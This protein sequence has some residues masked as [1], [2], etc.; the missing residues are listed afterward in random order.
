MTKLVLALT[1]AVAVTVLVAP[2]AF[3]AVEYCVIQNR[4]GQMG[5]TNADPTYGWTK[6]SDARCFGSLDAAQR[7]V[8]T[9]VSPPM[10]SGGYTVF[11][12]NPQAEA[13]FPNQSVFTE[14]LP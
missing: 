6:V 2:S 3:A 4:D 5:I 12:Q 8:G 9:G 10:I 1:A 14:G 11:H 7:D 13:K